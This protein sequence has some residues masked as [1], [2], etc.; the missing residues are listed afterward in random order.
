MVSRRPPG[1]VLAAVPLSLLDHSRDR[2]DRAARASGRP[3][4][5]G[6]TALSRGLAGVAGA[7]ERLAPMRQGEHADTGAG[8]TPVDAR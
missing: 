5:K 7:V 8:R 6:A 3:V 1:N 2:L 4:Q